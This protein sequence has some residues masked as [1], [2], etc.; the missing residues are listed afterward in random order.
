MLQQR[1]SSTTSNAS[2]TC[3]IDC[4]LVSFLRS[5]LP[6]IVFR[7]NLLKNG[8]LLFGDTITSQLYLQTVGKDQSTLLP[9]VRELFERSIQAREGFL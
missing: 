2:H 1:P 3:R 5:Q 9:N 8:H 6:F 4:S 7:L